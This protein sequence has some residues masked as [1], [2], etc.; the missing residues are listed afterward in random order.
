MIRTILFTCL[1]INFFTFTL[2]SQTDDDWFLLPEELGIQNHLEYSFDVENKKEILENWT[3][4]DYIKGI[5]SAGIRLEV[6]QPNDPDPSI[7]R[8]KVR[9][10]D[11]AY[12]YFTV[13]LGDFDRGV[14]LTAG[15]FYT[16]FGRGMILKSYEDR[17][18]RVD[19]NLIGFKAEAHL[20]DFYL[21]ALSGSAANSQNQRN[22]ILHA[23][24]FSYRGLS[25]LKLGFTHAANI[26]ELESISKTSFTSVRVEP[27]IWNFDL[28]FEFGVKQNSDI[29]K[30]IFSNNESIIG[31]GF[32]GN[33]NM[34]LGR[35][36]FTG[37]YKLYDNFAFTSNDVTIFYNTPPSLRKEYTY[38][39]LNSHPSPLDQSNEQ[40]FQIEL[41]YTFDE[42]TNF[43]TS[44][45]LT[46]TLPTGSYFQRVNGFNLP[47]VTQFK[48]LFLQTYRSWNDNL[49]TTL[50]FGYSEEL[51]SNTKNITPVIENK[52][53]FN[54]INTIKLIIEHQHTTNR[55]TSEKYYSDV[56]S[57][58]YLRSPSFNVAWVS[59][60]QT[61]ESDSGRIVRK[62]WSFIQFGYKISSHTDLSLLFGSRTAGNICIGGVCRFEPEFRGIEFKMLTRL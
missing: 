15:N 37:E 39:L 12:K 60:I 20:Y 32:Y 10:A 2:Y 25:F 18:I 27:S 26:P 23:I 28:Y 11:I 6:F 51:S 35:F 40:G 5:F 56:L 21:T 19:N 24:D 22:D 13:D 31:K 34:Y 46:Q 53:Y 58:E 8:G 44:Y 7:N 52:F 48:E 45:G 30:N 33:A 4:L 49:N 43:Q 9:Y 16:L 61:K 42:R 50:S 62:V 55:I 54:D 47:V 1:L 41:N 17:N 59:E 14:R 57:I 36:A 38:Q 3:N 29:K